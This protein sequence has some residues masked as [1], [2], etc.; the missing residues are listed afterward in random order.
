MSLN[1]ELWSQEWS[2]IDSIEG[3]L[4]EVEARQLYELARK[5]TAEVVVEIGSFLGRSTAA[6]SLGIR[7]SQRTGSKVYAVDTW[8]GDGDGS[9]DRIEKL[10]VNARIEHWNTL[11]R[12]ETSHF[13][14]QCQ[15]QS[16][17]WAKKWIQPIDVL[18]IDASHH[19][20]SV[21]ADAEAWLPRVR[22][23]GIIAFHD[24]W[25]PGPSQTIRELPS[26]VRRICVVDSLA[27]FAVG[28]PG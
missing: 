1:E 14:E 18:F 17:D 10:G 21:K 3:W 27:V 9:R 23:G 5:P 8:Q 26:H 11:V 25:A 12:T 13:V 28:A 4:S 15:G 20:E 7:T 24:E 6:L 16:T 19:Y 22:S 2:K